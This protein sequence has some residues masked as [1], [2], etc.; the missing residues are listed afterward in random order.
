MAISE[1]WTAP[2]TKPLDYVEVVSDPRSPGHIIVRPYFT[3][4]DRPEGTGYQLPENKIKLAHRLVDAM[5]D[6]AA[7][8][9]VKKLTD[10][11]GKTY[12]STRSVVGS[13]QLNADLR[14][15]GY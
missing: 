8:T 7:F 11:N 10:K 14:R 6:G 12:V 1:I 9:D 15:I 4:V 3:G 13:R 5:L 2:N